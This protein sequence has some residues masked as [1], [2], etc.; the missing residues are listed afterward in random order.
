MSMLARI[1]TTS[2][3]FHPSFFLQIYYH[4]PFD[5]PS[6][7]KRVSSEDTKQKSYISLKF[8]PLIIT[9]DEKILKNLFEFQRKCKFAS[10]GNPLSHFQTE[11][12]SQDLCQYECRVEKFLDICKCI[13][14]F[15]KRH[16]KFKI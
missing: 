2:L 3:I 5:L 13:P 9:S 15:Y 1:P 11:I 6:I 4:G 12:Y 14:F 8:A 16:C 10:E 7:S